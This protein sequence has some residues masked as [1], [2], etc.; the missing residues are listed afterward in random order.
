[1]IGIWICCYF[2]NKS[3]QFI[4]NA[5]LHR[6]FYLFFSLVN[7]NTWYHFLNKESMLERFLITDYIDFLQQHCN[8]QFYYP[9]RTYCNRIMFQMS[10]NTSVLQNLRS[11]HFFFLSFDVLSIHFIAQ[12]KKMIICRY[13]LNVFIT[14]PRTSWS[15]TISVTR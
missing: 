7:H 6:R 15:G 3:I 5:E 2:C 10:L 8:A 4:F 12:C 11:Q 9:Y 14:I 13:P 1:M